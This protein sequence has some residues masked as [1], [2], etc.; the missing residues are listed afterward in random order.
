M[1]LGFRS[2]RVVGQS[3]APTYNDGDWLL[4]RTIRLSSQST[5]G[6]E[7][8]RKI[9]GKVVLIRRQAFG[10]IT[11]D[12][13]PRDVLQVKRVTKI[14]ATGGISGDEFGIWVEGD[15]KEASTDSRQW[16]ALKPVE[17]VGVSLLRYR[18]GQ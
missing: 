6:R 10:W 5:K 17:V 12:E 15:N 1:A 16:G 7:K 3:M 9:S 8:I 2:V 14:D 11:G 13:S 18:K 4:F